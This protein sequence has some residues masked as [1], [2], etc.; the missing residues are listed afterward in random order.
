ML[1]VNIGLQAALG[2]PTPMVVVSSGSMEPTINIGDI[3]IIQK[4]PAEQYMVGNHTTH[5]GVVVVWNATGI[6]QTENN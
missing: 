4:I 5:T 2:T 3:C 6:R 1:G